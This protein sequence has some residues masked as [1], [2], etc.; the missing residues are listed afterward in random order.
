MMIAARNAFLMGGDKPWQNPYITDGLV[1]MW[2]GEWNAGGGVH[3]STATTWVDLTGNGHVLSASSPSWGDNYAEASTSVNSIFRGTAA[4]GSWLCD[5]CGS[6][7]TVEI[8]CTVATNKSDSV[9]FGMANGDGNLNI[10]HRQ[11]NAT[12]NGATIIYDGNA[13]LY[14]SVNGVATASVRFMAFAVT[15]DGV[16]TAYANGVARKTTSGMTIGIGSTARPYALWFRGDLYNASTRP[17]HYAGSKTYALRFYSRALD[18]A[19]V[20]ANYAIDAAR[21]GL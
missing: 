13:S 19:E 1:A 7:F 2:D 14:Y 17:H 3:D 4:Q 9:A 15:S 11:T 20:A 5:V 12:N 18:S 21:F 10:T 6:A 8:V 16:G